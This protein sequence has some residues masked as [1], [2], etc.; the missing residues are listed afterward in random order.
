[1]KKR[2]SLLLLALA[3]VFGAFS[4]GFFVG[5]NY[6]QAPIQLSTLQRPT[7]LPA[8]SAAETQPS[9][10]QPYIAD[11]QAQAPAESVPSVVTDP[12]LPTESAPTLPSDT[13][14]EPDPAAEETTTAIPDS[15]ESLP[16]Q[17]TEE[18]SSAPTTVTGLIDINTADQAT[19]M[20]LPGIGETLSKRIIDYRNANGPFG[21]VSELLNVSG[22]G[23]KRLSAILDYICAGG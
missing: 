22:I 1:M 18:T 10:A 17:T 4:T 12:Q 8:A 21:S 3:L 20:T 6:S 5:R 14:A 19:L 7:L 16:A 9:Y 15:T 11:A 2:G 23:E 13:Q